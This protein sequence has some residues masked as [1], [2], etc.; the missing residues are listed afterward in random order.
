VFFCLGILAGALFCLGYLAGQNSH[1][2]A[3][4]PANPYPFAASTPAPPGRPA[5]GSMP[6]PALATALR[7]VDQRTPLADPAATVP[8]TVPAGLGVAARDASTRR[9][10]ACKTVAWVDPTT[11]RHHPDQDNRPQRDNI[12]TAGPIRIALDTNLTARKGCDDQNRDRRSADNR[13]DRGNGGNRGDCR[14]CPC[15]PPGPGYRSDPGGY[16]YPGTYYPGSYPGGYGNP[17]PY[18][19]PG[20]GYPGYGYPG[21]GYPGYGYRGR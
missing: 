16:H 10:E 8:A 13:G 6:A 9:S 1:N 19:Y 14:A 20:Y 12:I 18:G 5:V 17:S 4:H 7:L 3:H 21:Y 11:A 15:P 2:S